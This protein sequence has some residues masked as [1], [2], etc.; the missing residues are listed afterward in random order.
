MLNLYPRWLPL[1]T[2]RLSTDRAWLLFASALSWC[3]PAQ[4]VVSSLVEHPDSQSH[5]GYSVC[6]GG[7]AAW[8]SCSYC[9]T[10]RP[11]WQGLWGELAQY[12]SYC[13]ICDPGLDSLQGPMEGLGSPSQCLCGLCLYLITEV[14]SWCQTEYSLVLWQTWLFVCCWSCCKFQNHGPAH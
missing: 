14:R 2:Q 7:A 1:M 13:Y 10:S 5:R 3:I 8:F 11:S 9:S 12:F 6:V 4:G